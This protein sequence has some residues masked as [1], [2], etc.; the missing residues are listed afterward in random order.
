LVSTI[1]FATPA[2][3]KQVGEALQ[4]MGDVGDTDPNGF[5]L[6]V[7]SIGLI[8]CVALTLIG[9]TTAY[10]LKSKKQVKK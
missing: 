8:F 3:A 4:D 10:M 5:K 1:F 7:I 9:V 6:M 2:F